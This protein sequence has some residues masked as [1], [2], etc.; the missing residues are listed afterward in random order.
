METVTIEKMK[1]TNKYMDLI[2]RIDNPHKVITDGRPI[3]VY[4]E[5]EV[6]NHSTTYFWIFN[7]ENL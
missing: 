1:S 4:C 2:A 7:Q 3:E 6:H 5:D